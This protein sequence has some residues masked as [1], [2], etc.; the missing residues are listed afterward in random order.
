MDPISVEVI[1]PTVTDLF[2]CLH[3]EAIFDR[4][5]VGPRVHGEILDEYPQ[6]LKDDFERLS[7]W[8]VELAG[9]YGDAVRIKLTDPQSLEGF[10]KCVRHRV[11]RYPAF[12]VAGR[13]KYVGWDKLAVDQVL[14]E[15]I[16]A[17]GPGSRGEPLPKGN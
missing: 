12:I 11:R 5:D 15:D 13:K 17:A 16:L 3:C 7:A 14:R 10:M 9:R 1:A 4:T 8:L 2:H 6:D